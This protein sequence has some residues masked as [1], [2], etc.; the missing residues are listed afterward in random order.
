[1]TQFH[2]KYRGRVEDN[3]DPLKLGRILAMVPAVAGARTNWA[4]PC[5]PYAA[6]QVGSLLVPPVGALVWIEFEAGDPNTPIWSGCF[7]Q[8]VEDMPG[9]VIPAPAK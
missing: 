2:G 4:L 7:W 6:P 3:N 5:A 1:M 8:R 9:V